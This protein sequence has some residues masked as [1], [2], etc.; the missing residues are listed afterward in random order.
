MHAGGAA[1]AQRSSEGS[2]AV[3]P[4]PGPLAPAHA[5]IPHL[6]S[7]SSSSSSSF[8]SH[9]EDDDDDDGGS[10]CSH[11]E[12]GDEMHD[13]SNTSTSSSH[14]YLSFPRSGVRGGLSVGGSSR[15]A[16]V[17]SQRVG[18]PMHE[19]DDEGRP[20]SKRVKMT[21]EKQL[22]TEEGDDEE[23]GIHD[24]DN[25]CTE[26]PA[27][28]AGSKRMSVDRGGGR[29]AKAIIPSAGPSLGKRRSGGGGGG[30]DDDNGSGSDRDK[31]DHDNGRDSHEGGADIA[32]RPRIKM[33]KCW[34]CTF[35][36]SKMARQIA[37]FVS[38]N[39]GTMDPAI[40]ADQIKREVLR[41][42]CCIE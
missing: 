31:D 14:L 10:S 33:S 30:D 38:A 23:E 18:R 20:C 32:P 42:V 3:Q 29:C 17:R 16:A 11:G 22:G 21:V 19:G 13:P 12:M 39:A 25:E 8:E 37:A 7:S 26:E 35:S 24:M 4:R 40:M 6:S 34:L 1:E 2:N 15:S 27:A 41:E 5:H 9:A 36:S 28:C